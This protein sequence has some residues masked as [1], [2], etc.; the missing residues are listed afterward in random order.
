[1]MKLSFSS[2]GCPEWDLATIA[3]AAREYGYDGVELRGA[4]REHISPE[5][6]KAERQQVKAMF[7]DQGVEI[8]CLCAYTRFA[9]PDADER[10]QNEADLLEFVDLATDVGAPYIRTFM[11]KF[12]DGLSD[13][14][15]YDGAADSLNRV[16]QQIAGSG[17][18][19]LIETHDSTSATARLKPLMER[20]SAPAIG[21]LWD[22]AHS[23]REGE[24][25]DSAYDLLGPRIKHVHLKDERHEN[26]Q[27]V[28]CLPGDGIMPISACRDLLD[29][30]GYDGY[31]SLEWERKWHPEMPPLREALPVFHD[32]LMNS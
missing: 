26:G 17:I 20:I 1:M 5:F 9:M 27:I 13:E 32:L 19:V 11:G 31:L 3:S 24:A 4:G 28:H 2:L 8:V 12:P 22:M 10:R 14:V 15:V 29:S 18:M 25:L 6:S 30:R 7:A 21:V 23:T 16:G